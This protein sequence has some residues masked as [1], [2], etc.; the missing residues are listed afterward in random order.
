MRWFDGIT[1]S[2]HEFE[3]AQGDGEGQGS[4]AWCGPWESLGSQKA[5]RDW[6]TEQ[7]QWTFYSSLHFFDKFSV[8]F[9]F[10]L[11]SKCML[12]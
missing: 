5:G 10:T 1:D 11:W 9:F 6:V 12:L 4:P 8:T 2:A 7:Q 3:Q